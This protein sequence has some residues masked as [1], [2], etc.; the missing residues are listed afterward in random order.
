[1]SSKYVRDEIFS[2]LAT[3]FPNENV[4]DMTGG[5][6]SL[7]SL[8]KLNNISV[9]ER[10]NWLGVQFVGSS[11]TPQ[12]LS[13]NNNTGKYRENGSIFIHVVSKTKDNFVDGVLTRAEALRDGFRGRRINDIIIEEMTPPNFS[14]GATLDLEAGYSSGTFIMAYERDVNL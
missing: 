5:F 8:L 10:Q 12:A 3:E 11:E 7:Q 4:V 9:R 1:M 14:S 6:Q 2:F 13:A